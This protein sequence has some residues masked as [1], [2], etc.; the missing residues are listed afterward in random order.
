MLMVQGAQT[1]GHSRRVIQSFTPQT[2][3]AP[4]ETVGE[5]EYADMVVPVY[6]TALADEREE[7][8]KMSSSGA[9]VQDEAV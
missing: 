8:G 4:S 7:Q 2:I 5:S 6:C 1:S 3:H 9:I